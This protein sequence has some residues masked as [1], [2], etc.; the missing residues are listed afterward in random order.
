MAPSPRPVVI[1][2]ERDFPY[3][4]EVAY[5]WLTDY[6][7]HDHERAGAIVKKRIVVRREHDK[8]GRVVEVEFD[9][10]LETFGQKTK[11]RGIVH[12]H[13]DERRW[14]A[15]L[16]DKARWVYEYRLVPTPG[17]SRILI[18]YR[19]GS[20]RLRRRVLLTIMKPFIRRE[21]DKM[22]DGFAAAM[23]KELAPE[24]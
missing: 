5:A 10:E 4:P 15:T 16:G 3:P 14:V 22:W 17:G 6:Q 1:H 18:D 2:Y 7:D 24:G 13:P 11:G 20:R 9:G 23:E 12:L 8:D 19:L 21:L